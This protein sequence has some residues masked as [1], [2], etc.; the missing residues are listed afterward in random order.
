MYLIV[1]D[2]GGI[3]GYSAL[4]II[5]ALMKEIEALETSHSDGQAS[6]SFHPLPPA[7][8]IAT[9]DKSV[10]SE[11]PVEPSQTESSPWLPCHYFDY[12]AGTS[13][14]G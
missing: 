13:T 14:G 3:R 4:L 5:Q 2:G 11:D 12:M 8:N 1:L 7:P 9:D 6:S 10:E